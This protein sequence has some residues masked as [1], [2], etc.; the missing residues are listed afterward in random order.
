MEIR[1]ASFKGTSSAKLMCLSRR[2]NWVKKSSPCGC[3]K[4]RHHAQG[5]T[6]RKKKK[7]ESCAVYYHQHSFNI[8]MVSLCLP[9]R[10]IHT[11]KYSSSFCVVE[12]VLHKLNETHIRFWDVRMTPI[13]SQCTSHVLAIVHRSVYTPTALLKK[14]VYFE[15]RGRRL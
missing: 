4:D 7:T 6:R 13:F 3:Y 1:S 9:K 2:T 15:T 12:S 14:R 11:I 5:N 10:K 8:L